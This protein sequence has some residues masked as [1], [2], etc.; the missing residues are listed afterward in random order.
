MDAL[1]LGGEFRHELVLLL[2]L[3]GEGQVG[4]LDFRHAGTHVREDKEVLV[5]HAARQHLMALV[6]HIHGV[7]LLVDHEI[8]RI[9]D[10]RHL[11]LVVLHV[12]ILRLLEEH[13]HA[14]LGK[15]LDER[16]VF[17]KALVGPQEQLSAFG[18]I[19]FGNLLLGLVEHLV[20]KRAL[21]LVKP[22]HVGAELHELRLVGIVVR[23]RTGNDERG[24]RIVD[25]HGVHLIYDGEVVLALH[26]VLLA[27]GH[28]V[29]EVVEAELI[30]RAEGDIAFVGL[31]AGVRIRLMLVDAVHGQS[32]KHVQRPHPLGVTLR[33]VVVD[34][35]HVHALARKGVQEH[36]QGRHE[37][38]AFAR[39][40]LRD[41]ALV[42]GDAADQ[43]HVVM[44]HI[45]GDLVA[46]RHPVVAVHGLVTLDVHEVVVHRQVAVELRRRDGDGLMFLEAAGRALHDGER[47]RKDLVE[48]LLDGLVLF[49][50]KLVRLP[51]QA[52]LLGDGNIFVELEP[53]LGDTVLKGFLH[54][55]QTL[56]QRRRAGADVVVGE[57]VYFGIYGQDLVQDRLHGLV[58][59]FGL[60]TEDLADDRCK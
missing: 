47:L 11:L 18:L 35:H 53:N 34:G 6:G 16:L 3:L 50:H 33:Q 13:L 19:A 40:H 24:A 52:L 9:G 41:L 42:Q 57:G 17:R 23:D 60:G 44:D 30:V 27:D 28:V 1:A 43:L 37:G 14:R 55:L 46:A 38:L 51:G 36:R 59:A 29:T 20:H 26:E 54:L 39:G 4:M 49:F 12:V 56:P 25:E 32:V 5:A 2:L 22:L 58:V 21:R 7:Q 31:A 48:G 8:E 10:H 15:E 45:P